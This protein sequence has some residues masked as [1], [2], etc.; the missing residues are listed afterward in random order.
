LAKHKSAIKQARMSLRRKEVNTK[1]RKTVK[2]FETKLIKAIET[3]DKALAQTLLRD[4]SSKIMIA[5]KKDVLHHRT[6]SRKISRLATKV[7]ALS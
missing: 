6:A 4:F 2:T 5:A 7:S 1:V 3:K